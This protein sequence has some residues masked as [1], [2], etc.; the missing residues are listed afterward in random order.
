[1]VSACLL[2]LNFLAAA[3]AAGAQTSDPPKD[4]TEHKGQSQP[5]G[6]TGPLNTESRTK[7]S[8]DS[9]QGDAP[10]GMQAKPK[11]DPKSQ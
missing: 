4:Q 7:A 5:Q 11:V 10:S 2:A 8:P 1:M 3:F 9:P 6:N